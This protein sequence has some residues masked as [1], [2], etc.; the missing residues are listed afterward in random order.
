MVGT[1]NTTLQIPRVYTVS[2][3][4]IYL[5]CKT[6]QDDNKV[7]QGENPVV[8]GFY[9]DFLIKHHFDTQARK[10]N[11][12]MKFTGLDA[13]FRAIICKDEPFYIKEQEAQIN[14]GTVRY[15]MSIIKPGV[16]M[17][18]G[19]AADVEAV[20]GNVEYGVAANSPLFAKL[21]SKI[22]PYTKAGRNYLLDD[23][24]I[25]SVMTSLGNVQRDKTATIVSAT[26][27]ALQTDKESY[28]V[29][30]NET[31]LG[32]KY[33]F[34][35][36]HDLTIYSGLDDLPTGAE[37]TVYNKF[38]EARKG[39]HPAYVRGTN[40]QGMPLFDLTCTIMFQEKK[41]Q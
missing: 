17:P 31:L 15:K 24:V 16:V 25:E 39:L 12:T 37:F 13:K 35:A 2:A 1:D 8:P 14:E 28:D 11:P 19:K 5:F 4:Q 7:H 18:D 41:A 21:N 32:N 36:K 6:T 10:I 3:E 9:L 20:E 30:F 40:S 34:F 22:L 38:G 27:H 33:P 29:L 26:S 23:K